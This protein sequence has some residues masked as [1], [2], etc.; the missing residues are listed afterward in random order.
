[1]FLKGIFYKLAFVLVALVSWIIYDRWDDITYAVEKAQHDTIKTA[2]K[3]MPKDEATVTK[4]YK[5]TDADGKVHYTNVKPENMKDVETQDIK[6]DQNLMESVSKF[7]TPQ[8]KEEE[9]SGIGGVFGHIPK[10]IQDTKNL[11]QTLNNR[12]QKM[13]D[14]LNS[15]VK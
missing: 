6:S 7:D 14:Q 2:K 12:A 4:T 13:D 9:K 10:A 1:M 3:I 15:E 5:W 11:E 8:K